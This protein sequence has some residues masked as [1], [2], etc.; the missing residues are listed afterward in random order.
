MCAESSGQPEKRSTACLALS[1]LLVA[2]RRA[3]TTDAGWLPKGLHGLVLNGGCSAVSSS[4]PSSFHVPFTNLG[5]LPQLTY[6]KLCGNWLPDLEVVAPALKT[7]SIHMTVNSGASLRSLQ[8]HPTLQTIVTNIE[9]LRSVKSVPRRLREIQSCW[10]PTHPPADYST[11]SQ[12]G[13][14]GLLTSASKT[15]STSIASQ[16]AAKF[17]E[18]FQDLKNSAVYH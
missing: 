8:H 14:A 7:L 4:F 9:K 16:Y 6:L 2:C 10:D 12:V 3:C 15:C 1:F 18:V 13:D 11:L 5:C 17:L